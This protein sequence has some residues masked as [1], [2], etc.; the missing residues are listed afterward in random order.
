MRSG[1]TPGTSRRRAEHA[2]HRGVQP[3]V[4]AFTKQI[5]VV[6]GEHACP[7]PGR[8]EDTRLC[9]P[10]RGGFRSR[11][12]GTHH[13]LPRS[14]ADCPAAHRAGIPADPGDATIVPTPD[15]TKSRKAGSRGPRPLTWCR[16]LRRSD[17]SRAATGTGACV[18]ADMMRQQKTRGVPRLSGHSLRRERA[19][20]QPF[21]EGPARQRVGPRDLVSSLRPSAPS[22]ASAS[23]TDQ[24]APTNGQIP[25][26]WYCQAKFCRCRD[27]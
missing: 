24:N 23:A 17:R 5:D 20:M 3:A 22:P 6:F 26:L 27:M 1:P 8:P 7:C 15:A 18:T 14:G 19:A 25:P 2:T 21:P 12:S 10:S 11:A 9:A 4:G 16:L 13:D